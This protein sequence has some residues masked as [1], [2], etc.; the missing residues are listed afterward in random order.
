MKTGEQKVFKAASRSRHTPDF[1]SQER[2]LRLGS[3][4]V[5]AAE[6]PPHWIWRLPG[7]ESLPR[8]DMHQLLVP[9]RGT[10]LHAVWD[11]AESVSA[12]GELYLHGR[13]PLQMFAFE[14]VDG[15]GPCQAV[16]LG[17]PGALPRLPTGG[18]D[19]LR[20]RRT[21]G[22]SG[23]GTLLTGFLTQLVRHADTFRPSDSPRLGTALLDLLSAY[24][25]HLLESAPATEPEGR[26]RSLTLRISAFIQQHLHDPELSPA[27][28]AAGHHI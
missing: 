15:R 11:G 4:L 16:S 25:A 18:I 6:L 24:F 13:A 2:E 19:R 21:A 28:I 23:V 27:T 26:R 14:P 3:V 8:P 1:A 17:F 10:R 20:G 7:R 12:T 5:R 9:L 22:D